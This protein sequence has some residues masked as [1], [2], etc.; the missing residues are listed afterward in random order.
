MSAYAEVE[1]PRVIA[2]LNRK[3]GTKL[4]RAL[5]RSERRLIGWPAGRFSARVRFLVTKGGEGF[6]W[7]SR[8][9]NDGKDAVNLFGHGMPGDSSALNID[10]QFNLPVIQFS[11]QTGGAFLTDTE[12]GKVLLAH[13]GIVTLGHGRVARDALIREMACTLCEAQTSSGTREFLVIGELDSPSLVPDI[14]AFATELRR[15]ARVLG[16]SSAAASKSRRPANRSS[17]A[18]TNYGAFGKLRKY[19]DEVTGKRTIKARRGPVVADC[20]HGAVVRALRDTLGAADQ[21][22]KSREIDLVALTTKNVFVVEVKTSASTQNV[23]TALG[24]LMIH[25]PAVAKLLPGR[26]VTKL[27]V[28]PEKPSKHL[29]DLLTNELGVRVLTFSRAAN[30]QVSFSRLGGLH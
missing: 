20:Y 6:W 18:R 3:L 4:R 5:R 12:T 7:A 8:K 11:R 28:L 9:S 29:F 19:F 25:A 21:A 27:M 14:I 17:G 13:R 24:Q 1:E 2:Q 16:E 26:R 22:L 23:Y 10:V 30:G 15:A